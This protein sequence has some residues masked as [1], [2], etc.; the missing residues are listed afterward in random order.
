[1]RYISIVVFSTPLKKGVIVG[2]K[3][4]T[5]G[6]KKEM[7]MPKKEGDGTSKTKGRYIGGFALE[8]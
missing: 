7:L 5:E 3:V 6:L 4:R 2:V 8:H 1:M